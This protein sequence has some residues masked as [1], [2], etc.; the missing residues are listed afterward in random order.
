MT[1]YLDLL[2]VRRVKTCGLLIA[3][4]M[5]TGCTSGFYHVQT[6]ITFRYPTLDITGAGA[7]SITLDDV[8]QWTESARARSDILKPVFQ[9]EVMRPDEAFVKSGRPLDDPN[10]R[11]T[12]FDLRK[13]D[14]RCFIVPSSVRTVRGIITS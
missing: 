2:L 6:A 3:A 9:V 1:Q 10:Q 4:I 8:N 12:V 13:K 5:L 14:G 11:M 7:S